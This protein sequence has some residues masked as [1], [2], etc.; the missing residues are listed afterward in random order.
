[1]IETGVKSC[2]LVLPSLTTI[3]VFSS[4]SQYQV[5]G[6]DTELVDKVMG[7]HLPI[8]KVFR[9]GYNAGRV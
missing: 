6:P 5:F 8:P 1:M 4:Y 9:R 7:I 2:W 3:Y